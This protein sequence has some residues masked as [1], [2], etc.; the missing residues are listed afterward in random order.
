MGFAH[1]IR[2]SGRI[3]ANTANQP[4]EG[5]KDGLLTEAFE[6]GSMRSDGSLRRSQQDYVTAAGRRHFE[7][8][9]DMETR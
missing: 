6:P 7:A 9:G 2:N 8:E 5:G 4:G 3:F 1:S